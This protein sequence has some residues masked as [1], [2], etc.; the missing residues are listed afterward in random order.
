MIRPWRKRTK[1]ICSVAYHYA[2]KTFHNILGGIGDRVPSVFLGAGVDVGAGFIELSH[3]SQ[4]DLS[5]FCYLH[6]W[7]VCSVGPLAV[8]PSSPS[9]LRLTVVQYEHRTQLCTTLSLSPPTTTKAAP[10]PPPPRLYWSTV[11]TTRRGERETGPFIQTRFDNLASLCRYAVV[12]FLYSKF[13]YKM[14]G[15]GI[16]WGIRQIFLLPPPL[17]KG[18][19]SSARF[20]L[21][22]PVSSP[23]S[24]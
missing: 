12:F 3:C 10:A 21:P 24:A 16:F 19:R 2:W 22:P 15:T 9:H 17:P 1:E 18:R 20:T 4:V 6:W 11:F 23:Q 14:S 13:S 8:L 7:Y 5:S